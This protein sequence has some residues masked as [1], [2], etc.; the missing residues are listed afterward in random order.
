[1][2]DPGLAAHLVAVALCSVVLGWVLGA[3]FEHRRHRCPVVPSDTAAFAVRRT[4]VRIDGPLL[5]YPNVIHHN[6][7]TRRVYVAACGPAPEYVP[8]WVDQMGE[9]TL[10]TCRVRV[11]NSAGIAYA[12]VTVM[13][14]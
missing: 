3:R 12:M 7:N 8:L 6:L 11:H 10:N 1:M 4:S 9:A 5:A 2:N 13:E 14:G